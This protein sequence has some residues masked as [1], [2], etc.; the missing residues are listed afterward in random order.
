[1][2]PRIASLLCVDLD[3][4]RRA[5][6]Q[7]FALSAFGAFNLQVYRRFAEDIRDPAVAQAL[8]ASLMLYVAAPQYEFAKRRAKGKGPEGGQA[9][10][11]PAA[12]ML[13]LGSHAVLFR[14]AVSATGI[15]P[16]ARAAVAHLDRNYPLRDSGRVGI[17]FRDELSMYAYGLLTRL[18]ALFTP[19]LA[20]YLRSTGAAW[21]GDRVLLAGMLEHAAIDDQTYVLILHALADPPLGAHAP[22]AEAQLLGRATA[23]PQRLN[24]MLDRLR[25]EPGN[26][27]L[28][29]SLRYLPAHLSAQATAQLARCLLSVP[30]ER[31]R[32]E[33]FSAIGEVIHRDDAAK[34]RALVRRVVARVR[35]HWL[36]AD[37]GIARE[38]SMFWALVEMRGDPAPLDAHIARCARENDALG[39]ILLCQIFERPSMRALPRDTARMMFDVGFG[40]FEYVHDLGCVHGAVVAWLEKDLALALR[41][42]YSIAQRFASIDWRDHEDD[43]ELI[44]STLHLLDAMA[45]SD[46]HVLEALAVLEP[47]LHALR[48]EEA[49]RQREY[50][51]A[52]DVDYGNNASQEADPEMLGW[53]ERSLRLI[54]EIRAA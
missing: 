38:A 19:Y 30:T 49:A 9:R 54:A 24:R 29:A 35:E 20:P 33:W 45:I 44:H 32:P 25:E 26:T 51:D 10:I 12:E 5:L 42:R 13:A 53:V 34:G 1:M 36:N 11:E 23:T 16:L 2:V 41:L 14:H 52:E 22:F 43:G 8:L 47:R 46:L 17:L 37:V 15:D 31:V 4:R 40:N 7:L 27:F 50:A 21:F 6:A 48:D 28:I 39:L 18:A 3:E